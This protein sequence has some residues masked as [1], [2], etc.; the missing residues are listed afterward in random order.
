MSSV[1]NITFAVPNRLSHG[2]VDSAVGHTRLEFGGP[3][4]LDGSSSY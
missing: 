1:G 2:S 4:A 3:L